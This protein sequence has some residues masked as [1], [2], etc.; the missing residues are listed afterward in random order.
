MDNSGSISLVSINCGLPRQVAWHGR[1]LPTAIYREPVQGPRPPP[2]AQSR[3][4]TGK[5]IAA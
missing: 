5:L 3:A 1:N 4:E 2:H